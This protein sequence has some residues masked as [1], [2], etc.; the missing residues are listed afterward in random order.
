MKIQIDT[1]RKTVTVLEDAELSEVVEFV[2]KLKGGD[3]YKIVCAE[4]ERQ[5]PIT[6]NTQLHTIPCV[7][8]IPNITGTTTS[9]YAHASF[10]TN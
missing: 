9:G 10:I 7:D 1:T 3:S 2:S 6:W 8:G 4:V 5:H